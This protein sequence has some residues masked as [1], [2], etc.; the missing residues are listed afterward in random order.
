[1]FNLL[2]IILIFEE[3]KT[4]LEISITWDNSTLEKLHTLRRFEWMIFITT[5]YEIY[6]VIRT[7]FWSIHTF[8]VFKGDVFLKRFSPSNLS[9]C[10]CLKLFKKINFRS[11]TNRSLFSVASSSS[12]SSRT[13]MALRVGFCHSNY[14]QLM[15]KLCYWE[16]FFHVMNMFYFWKWSIISKRIKKH[17]N[18]KNMKTKH[19][20]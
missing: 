3:E 10:E 18:G 13:Q 8:H 7:K 17:V 2:Y 12:I 20:L 5:F 14:F 9:S 1:M 4:K 16:W 6:Y 15:P 19:H 11:S